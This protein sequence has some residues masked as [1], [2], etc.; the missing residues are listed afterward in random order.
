MCAQEPVTALLEG[1]LSPDA[2]ASVE[3]HLAE[4]PVCRGQ[5]RAERSLRARL[6]ESNRPGP[7]AGLE[8][9]VARSVRACSHPL[10]EP[11]ICPSWLTALAAAAGLLGALSGP[12]APAPRAH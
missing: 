8:R 3:A 5:A 1:A 6:R 12:K 11:A 4:C 10:D 9:M 7:T 2:A